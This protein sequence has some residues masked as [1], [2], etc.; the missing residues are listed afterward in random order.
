MNWPR[1]RELIWM[2]LALLGVVGLWRIGTALGY[3]GG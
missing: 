2:A 1:V 3:L